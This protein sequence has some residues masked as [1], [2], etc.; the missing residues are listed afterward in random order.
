MTDS[1]PPAGRSRPHFR[2]GQLTYLQ[3]PAGDP[4]VS[5]AFY[6]AVFGWEIERPYAS[7][8]A[9]GLFGQW[10]EDRQPVPDSGLMI[11]LH[12]DDIEAT[13][14]SVTAQGHE[15]LQAPFADGP[16]RTLATFLDP[17][18]NAIGIVELRALPAPG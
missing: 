6:E 15:I 11:W 12:V 1:E 4:M 14:E 16:V 3:I 17:G 9:P 13:L 10:V 18:G 8:I 2:H 5:G 7:F